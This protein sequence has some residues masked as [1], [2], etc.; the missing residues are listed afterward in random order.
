[1]TP[2][3]TSLQSLNSSNPTQMVEMIEEKLNADC[4]SGQ[5]EA[6]DNEEIK[7]KVSDGKLEE[8]LPSGLQTPMIIE[9]NEGEPPK[10]TKTEKVITNSF[11]F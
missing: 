5:S 3:H 2:L 7:I 1:M 10:L 11:A 6:S 9:I 4:D 8:P